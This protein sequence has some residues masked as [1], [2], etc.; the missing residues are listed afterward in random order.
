M[1]CRIAILGWTGEVAGFGGSAQTPGSSRCDYSPELAARFGNRYQYIAV[2]DPL[3]VEGICS[4]RNAH[5]CLV[6]LPESLPHIQDIQAGLAGDF[7]TLRA[8]RGSEVLTGQ[9]PVLFILPIGAADYYPRMLPWLEGLN[10]EL[11]Q[12][13]GSFHFRL[14]SL[15][16]PGG[17]QAV[18]WTEISKWLGYVREYSRHAIWSNIRT[19]ATVFCLAFLL[20]TLICG[21]ILLSRD[22]QLRDWAAVK[23][24]EFGIVPPKDTLFQL[25]SLGPMVTRLDEI[26]I[27]LQSHPNLSADQRARLEKSRERLGEFVD[28]IFETEGWP[29]VS[30][31]SDVASLKAL[32][33]SLS[34]WSPPQTSQNSI[35]LVEQAEYKRKVILDALT[36]AEK[37]LPALE[38]HLAKAE[39]LLGQ[40][41]QD[42]EAW[43]TWAKKC[44][45]FFAKPAILDSSDPLWSLDEFIQFKQDI[46]AREVNIR[47]ALELASG[48]GLLD[49]PG[50]GPAAFFPC[51]DYKESLAKLAG[52]RETI[53]KTAGKD[54]SLFFAKLGPG[55]SDSLKT[56][57]SECRREWLKVGR[58]E[59][60]A[61]LHAGLMPRQALQI[62]LE[63]ANG[64]ESMKAYG[65]WMEWLG[66]FDF[67]KH[68]KERAA[69]SL[70]PIITLGRYVTSESVLLRPTRCRLK[71]MEADHEIED[72]LILELTLNG[73]VPSIKIRLE[74][75]RL[76]KG[77]WEFRFAFPDNGSQGINWDWEQ[78]VQ[79]EVMGKNDKRKIL[80]IQALNPAEAGN[81]LGQKSVVLEWV[82]LPDGLPIPELLGR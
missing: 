72:E 15:E 53:F 7:R 8:F 63:K 71:L 47:G 10:R 36:K 38:E 58:E 51:S 23:R 11:G 28:A 69:D 16:N 62:W 59:L 14:G 12:G 64:S 50:H 56:K 52:I 48:L 49:P 61:R 70:N 4:L 32:A 40:K 68:G 67:Q 75:M 19:L 57:S 30:E 65:D 3:S 81:L 6:F 24:L 25:K 73:I 18:G 17:Q 82:P 45:D 27:F 20:F 35:P 77:L 54:A 43:D 39:K 5:G 80:E 22:E 29:E 21:S 44:A 41:N 76:G 2:P 78:S 1:T 74:G 37:V 42:N 79:L 9:M 26:H 31:V 34:A 13:F 33:N 55:L 66:E 46:Q 60:N